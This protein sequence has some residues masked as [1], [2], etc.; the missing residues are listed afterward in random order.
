MAI[1]G[2]IWIDCKDKNESQSWIFHGILFGLGWVA[3]DITFA[4]QISCQIVMAI[5]FDEWVIVEVKI[6]SREDRFV[7]N[8]IIYPNVNDGALLTDCYL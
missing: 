5:R 6:N 2:T 8:I 1:N 7:F 4:H 3:G